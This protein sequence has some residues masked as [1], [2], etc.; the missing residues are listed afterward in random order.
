M[1]RRDGGGVFQEILRE[2]RREWSA[3]FKMPFKV[4]ACEDLL[5][6]LRELVGE[7]RV[8]VG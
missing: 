8:K 2:L 6:K 3:H 5:A 7:D 4:D 1:S